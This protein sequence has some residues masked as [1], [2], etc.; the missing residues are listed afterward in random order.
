MLVQALLLHKVIGDLKKDNR[1]HLSTI[2]DEAAKRAKLKK[3]AL[4]VQKQ[5]QV[6][7][8]CQQPTKCLIV[9]LQTI[10]SAAAEMEE[11]DVRH[12]VATGKVLLPSSTSARE[13]FTTLT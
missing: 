13:F 6:N 8:C 9:E 2:M 1:D 12:Q 10:R 4:N 3:Q 7:A 5:N 11:Q